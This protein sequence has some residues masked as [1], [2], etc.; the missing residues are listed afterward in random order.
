MTSQSLPRFFLLFQVV[1]FSPA[2]VDVGYKTVRTAGAGMFNMGNTCYLNSTLQALFHT[3]ALYNYLTSGSHAKQC[4][5]ATGVS[6]GFFGH[7]CMICV[8]TGTLKD[9]LTTG[10]MRPT[11]VYEKLKMICVIK[12]YPK[13]SKTKK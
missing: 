10:V 3:P 11:K 9:T 8:M 12:Y 6:N 4:N 1:Y 5:K 7:S 13:L 2:A